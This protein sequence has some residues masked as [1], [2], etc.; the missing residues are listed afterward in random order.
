VPAPGLIEYDV[1]TP[2]WSDGALKK[3]WMALPGTERI[4]FSS[5]G[6]WSFPIGTVFVKHFEL[7]QSG[8]P[9]RLETRVMLHQEDRWI[10]FT[11]RWNALGTDA[12]LL[13]DGLREDIDLSGGGSQTWSYPSPADCLTCHSA[14]TGRV[15]GVRTPQL[16]R[17]FDFALATDNQLHAWNCIGLFDTDIGPPTAFGSYAALSDDTASRSLRARSYLAANCSICHQPG[18]ALTSMDLRSGILLGDMNAIGRLPIHGDL[19]V[20]TSLLIDPGDHANSVLWLRNDSMDEF[21]R[22]PKGTLLA[23]APAVDLLSDWID[24][25]L[26]DS[27]GLTAFLDSDEDGVEDDG[28]NCPAV[29]NSGQGDSDS[30]GLGD[31]CDP[32]RMPDLVAQAS[33]PA[34]ASAGSIVTIGATISN[35]GVDLAASSQVRVHLSKDANL[36]ASDTLLGDCFVGSILGGN[37]D[38]CLDTQVQIPD[39]LASM[40][41]TYHW[42]VCA[43]GLD[44]I[45]EADETNNCG[46]KTVL[47]PEAEALIQGLAAMGA[48]SVFALWRRRSAPRG[49]PP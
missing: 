22:M 49:G 13:R 34:S 16:N 32:D 31:P 9:R 23:D 14:P 4:T 35:T 44:L 24:L 40:P 6:N 5:R 15:L 46:V 19:G 29:S 2:L 27:G 48:A 30:D 12:D 33:G 45:E 36:G 43:D 38:A 1:T 39:E 47:I 26:W 20:P 10:G 41:G 11:Y 8:A 42:I 37:G 21:V 18:T 17:P 25:D 3:R 7:S 28:D